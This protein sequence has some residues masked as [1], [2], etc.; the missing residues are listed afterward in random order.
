MGRRA[1]PPELQDA[2]GNPGKRLSKAARR[3]AQNERV[4]AMLAKSPLAGPVEP[5]AA[6]SEPVYADALRVWREWGPELEKTN[7]L[8]PLHR[9]SFAGFCV[10]MAEYW[11]AIDDIRTHGYTQNVKTVAGGYMERMR[12]A[13]K[14]RE[15][16][17][18]RLQVAVASFGLTPREE[19]ALFKD[20]SIVSRENPSLFGH[21]P[22][23][24]APAHAG[25]AEPDEDQTPGPAASI[26]IGGLAALKSEPPS[27]PN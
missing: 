8:Q 19:Y 3:Q 12:P 13:V 4:A 7:R 1:D 9:L 17:F 5:P 11:W 22:T 15:L 25:P 18:S 2:K 23:Q 26:A 27:R 21:K 14:I 20:Q 24:A 6:F 10:D 16:A